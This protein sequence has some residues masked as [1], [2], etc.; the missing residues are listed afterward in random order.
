MK[1]EREAGT[2][3]GQF[4]KWYEAF[5]MPAEADWFKRDTDFPEMYDSD[6]VEATWDG[7]QN[8]Y[9]AGAEAQRERAKQIIAKYTGPT[10]GWL[11]SPAEIE[12]LIN[13]S[14]PQ[15]TIK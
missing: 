4:E 12:F 11:E 8:G 5:L 14:E 7:W 13:R 6:D 2:M 9:R 1:P 3:R 10:G 15:R